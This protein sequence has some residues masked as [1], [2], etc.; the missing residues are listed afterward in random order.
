[1]PD[2]STITVDGSEVISGAASSPLA[3]SPGSRDFDVVVVAAGGET[4]ATT[5][6]GMGFPLATSTMA[7]IPTSFTPGRASITVDGAVVPSGTSTTAT[8]LDAGENPISIVVTPN[9]RP[10]ATYDVGVL[11]QSLP[12]SCP[13]N[14]QHMVAA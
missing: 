7:S 3:L 8:A 5:S 9:T 11:R 13:A 6:Y 1:M 10:P 12:R 2:G 14:A 4:T